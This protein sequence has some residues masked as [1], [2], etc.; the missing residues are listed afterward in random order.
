MP[1]DMIVLGYNAVDNTFYAERADYWRRAGNRPQEIPE[2]PYF[3]SVSRFVPEKNLPRLIEAFGRYRERAPV[4]NR[5]DLVLCGDGP[6]ASLIDDAIT[7]SSHRSAIHR[8]GFL[9]AD[10]LSC[11][12]AYASGF[13]L[14]SISEPW[15]L[16]KRGGE[17]WPSSVA[18]RTS[19]LLTN[20]GFQLCRDDGGVFNPLDVKDLTSKLV[21]LASN[22]SSE[23]Q[24]MGRRAIEVVGC[25]G[26]ERFAQGMLQAVKLALPQ[27]LYSEQQ[28]LNPLGTSQ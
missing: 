25:W 21:W 20:T 10:D 17:Y 2:S 6:Q 22:T 18:L 23:R 14:P 16:Y 24:N 5:W 13:V 15:G 27:T 28:L 3:L 1:V 7:C 19:W 26:P 12:Y 8:P 9:Q 11:W 4:H